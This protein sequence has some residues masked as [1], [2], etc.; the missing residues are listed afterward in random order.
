MKTL[1][2]HTSPETAVVIDDYPYG[3]TLR[4]KIRYWMEHKTRFGYRLVSQTTNP[5]R[6][7]EFWN[8]PKPSTYS[9][10]AVMVE[11]DNGHISQRALRLYPSVEDAEAFWAD[12][13]GVLEGTDEGKLL[14]IIRKVAKAAVTP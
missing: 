2:G 6:E 14:D 10:L 11:L 5:K 13:G 1:T 12:H 4:C 9:P 8:K 3:Y 7:G